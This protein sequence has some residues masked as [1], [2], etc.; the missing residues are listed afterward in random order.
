M[1]TDT[2]DTTTDWPE[3]VADLPTAARWLY[4][5]LDQSDDGH[6]CLSTIREYTGMSTRGIRKAVVDLEESGVIESRWSTDD[7]R[8]RVVVLTE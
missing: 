4:R 8:E 3:A 5:L 2:P 1:T 6:L 7:A